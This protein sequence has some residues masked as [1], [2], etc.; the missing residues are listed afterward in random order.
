[1]AFHLP[2]PIEQWEGVQLFLEP[3]SQPPPQ[4]IRLTGGRQSLNGAINLG[5]SAS[6]RQPSSGRLL[7]STDD[8]QQRKHPEQ[9]PPNASTHPDHY[10]E[11]TS[12]KGLLQP[13]LGPALTKIDPL[14]AVLRPKDFIFPRIAC[15]DS[16]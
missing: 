4:K 5:P 14:E 15:M 6:R 9:Q 12:P 3:Q 10:S 2:A 13:P 11:R 16:F 1:M 8:Q 7:A